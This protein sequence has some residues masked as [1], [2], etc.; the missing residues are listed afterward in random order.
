MCE[1]A[2][3]YYEEH[4][5]ADAPPVV[6]S[7]GL[8]GSAAY[9][10][11]NVEALLAAG[12]RVVLYDHRGTG[13]SDRDL[14]P[15]LTVD[16]MADDLWRLISSLG[17]ENVILV[18]HAL[19]G[20]ISLCV[21]HRAPRLVDRVVVINGLSKPDSHFLRCFET[22]LALLEL[23]VR[24]FLH[25]QP[26]FLYP[27][28]WSSDHADRL[29]ADERSQFEHFQGEENVMAR[30]A[31]LRALDIDARLPEI[32]CPVLLIVAEDDM[33]VPASCSEHLARIL[34]NATLSR[35]SGGHACTVSEADRF[36]DILAGNLH[37][38]RQQWLADFGEQPA[39]YADLRSQP[40]DRAQRREIWRRFPLIDDQAPRLRREDRVLGI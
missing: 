25:A 14:P 7:P 2:G 36:N 38:D 27:A 30:I 18:G 40:G 8:G 39:I 29:R 16:D 6:L 24:E 9:W 37:P 28:R 35:M 4:G 13:R 10:G 21:A 11:P 33:L 12:H 34:P 15:G 22:R 1:V 20:V 26:I 17:D 32:G 3:L 23:G 19:G 5:P 31:A